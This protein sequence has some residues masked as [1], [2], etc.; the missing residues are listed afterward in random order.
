ME[1]AQKNEDSQGLQET[2]IQD[3]NDEDKED[4]YQAKDYIDEEWY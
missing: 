1:Q 2:Y 4:L 3:F